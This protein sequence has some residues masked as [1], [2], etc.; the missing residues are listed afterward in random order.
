MRLEHPLAAFKLQWIEALGFPGKRRQK[1]DEDANSTWFQTG[2]PMQSSALRILLMGG[3]DRMLVA[4]GAGLALYRLRRPRLLVSIMKRVYFDESG[5]TGQNL[6]DESD[7]IFVLAACSFASS[8]VQEAFKPLQD[9]KGPELK[10]SRLRKTTGGQQAVLAFL[11]SACLNSGTAAAVV[12][13]KPYMVV[14]KYCDLVLEPSMRMAGVDF[15]A[16]GLNLA[17]ANLLT[18]RMPVSLNPITWF[19]FLALFVRVVRER[20]PILFNQWR[21]SAELIHSHLE[22]AQPE[23]AGYVA[24]ILLVRNADEFLRTL[25]AD[26]LDPLVPAYHVMAEHWGKSIG[27]HYDLVADESKVL[28]KERGN[29]LRMSDSRLRHVIV[30]YDR[31]KIELPLMVANIIAVDST[32]EQ[33]VQFADILGGAIASA[34]KARLRAPLQNGTFGRK[35]FET[36]FSKGLIINAVW[37]DNEVDPKALETDTKPGPADVDPATYAAMVFQSHSYTKKSNA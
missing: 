25:I 14:T 35:I 16:H 13:H 3:D 9:F 4:E 1:E 20:S 17:T 21:T 10:F 32:T 18:T 36:C 31:R 29:L 23:L 33:Q 19:E 15:Y 11:N 22:Y 34:A 8:Q 26:E 28:A 30:G 5:N 6:L 2:A 27:T 24:P 7:P 12:F 37:P